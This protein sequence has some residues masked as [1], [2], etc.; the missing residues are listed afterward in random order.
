VLS[1]ALGV[2]EEEDEGVTLG[3]V[4]VSPSS[5]PAE[6]SLPTRDTVVPVP[7]D[8]GCPLTRSYPVI[9][10]A[11]S[12]NTARLTATARLHGKGVRARLFRDGVSSGSGS[13]AGMIWVSSKL[14]EPY[15]DA[16]KVDAGYVVVRSTGAGGADAASLLGPRNTVRTF[17]RPVR[18]DAV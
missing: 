5:E 15:V 6:P 2:L 13:Q 12:A 1:L 4:L 17:S 16:E 10:T 14:G 9:R 18:N 8:S 11:A 3:V 7:P